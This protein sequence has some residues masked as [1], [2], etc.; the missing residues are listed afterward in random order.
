MVEYRIEY[1]TELMNQSQLQNNWGID[2]WELI[3]I[4]EYNDQLLYHFIRK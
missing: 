2:G 4:I 1:V 3:A